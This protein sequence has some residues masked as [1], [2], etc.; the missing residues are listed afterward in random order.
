ME[1]L[2]FGI[3]HVLFVLALVLLVRDMRTLV[4]TITAFTVGHSITLSLAALGIVNAPASLFETAIAFSI[5]VLAA[6]LARGGDGQ[7]SA[8]RRRPWL[9]SAG[10][11]LLHGL[12]FAGALSEIGLPQAEV[13]LALFAFNVGVEIG[14]LLVVVPVALLLAALRKRGL[15]SPRWME[16]LPAW[17]IGAMAGYWTLE[18]GLWMIG[19]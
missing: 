6:E 1:H 9:V 16:S 8:L 10:F 2:L 17:G 7:S 19:L 11:G 3:D 14:Q 15:Y 12:G 18:R 5:V 4:A 13:P